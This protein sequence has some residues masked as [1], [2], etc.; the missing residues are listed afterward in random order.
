MERLGRHVG[1]SRSALAERFSDV[2]GE[3]IFA[4]L[5]RWR[6][7]LA[8]EALLA[9]SRSIGAIAR[10]AGYESAGAFSAAFKRT[11]GKPPSVWRRRV[12][13]RRPN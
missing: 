3:P 4:F 8:A 12:A 7:Q 1:L 6:L 5:T 11:F 2:M 9:T 10:E 13:N